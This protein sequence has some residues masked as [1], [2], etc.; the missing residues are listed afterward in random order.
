MYVEDMQCCSERG[1]VTDKTTAFVWTLC[2]HPVAIPQ[3]IYEPL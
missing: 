2:S 1:L 3:V